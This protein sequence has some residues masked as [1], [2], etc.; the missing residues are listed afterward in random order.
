MAESSRQA[1]DPEERSGEQAC[2]CLAELRQ[3]LKSTCDGLQDAFDEVARI[4]CLL[5]VVQTNLESN[6]LGRLDRIK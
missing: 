5:D 2:D 3:L 4:R 6:N 1:V